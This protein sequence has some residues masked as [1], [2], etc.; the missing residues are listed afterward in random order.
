[1]MR[2]KTAAALSLVVIFVAA[3]A[4]SA[5]GV[6]AS[7]L[8]PTVASFAGN[9]PPPPLSGKDGEG[10]LSPFFDESGF[11]AAASAPSTSA[12]TNGSCGFLPSVTIHY[13]WDYL[14]N[15]TD[16]SQWAHLD[17][18][19]QNRQVTIHQTDNKLEAGGEIVGDGYVFKITDGATGFFDQFGYN[20]TINGIVTLDDGTK[21]Q[22]SASFS[23]SLAEGE[24]G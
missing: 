18:D 4:D 2:L 14:N 16:N 20:L 23:G 6:P 22:A 21:C 3:C 11:L 15:T 7:S 5:T 1:M 8:H 9:P 12:P 10:E 24:I 13:S 19:G 17:V